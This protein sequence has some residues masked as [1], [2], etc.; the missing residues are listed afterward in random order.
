M[1]KVKKEN[2]G[3]NKVGNRGEGQHLANLLRNENRVKDERSKKI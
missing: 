3:G 1:E 2:G